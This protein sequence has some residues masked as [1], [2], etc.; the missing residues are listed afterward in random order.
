MQQASYKYMEQVQSQL[1]V[2]CFS[3]KLELPR[4]KDKIKMHME[5][6]Q[7]VNL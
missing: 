3:S 2:V 6:P 5:I 1:G 7:F 4:T